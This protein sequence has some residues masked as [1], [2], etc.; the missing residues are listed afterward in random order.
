MFSGCLVEP[1]GAAEQF[2]IIELLVRWNFSW[3]GNGHGFCQKKAAAIARVADALR[4]AGAPGEPSRV[5]SVLQKKGDIEF[6]RAQLVVRAVRG[7]INLRVR[8]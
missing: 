3:L 6:L 8:R 2:E 5:E 4:D 1:S 7:R